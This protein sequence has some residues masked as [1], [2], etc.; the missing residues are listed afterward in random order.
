MAKRK[1]VLKVTPGWLVWHKICPDFHSLGLLWWRTHAPSSDYVMESSRQQTSI[2]AL[3]SFCAGAVVAALLQRLYNSHSRRKTLPPTNLTRGAK[4]RGGAS[5]S[6]ITCGMCGQQKPANAF[7]PK[8]QK[9][10]SGW[11]RAKCN[12]CI[13]TY[14]VTF[15]ANAKSAAAATAVLQ[16]P[17]HS[18]SAS[19][20]D[21]SDPIRKA[22]KAETVLR[23]RTERILLVLEHCSDDLN[24]VAVM[25]TCEA[26]GIYRVWLI[27]ADAKQEATAR[28]AG[29]RA[30]Q[31][32]QVRASE[33]GFDFDRLL[34]GKRAQ[35]YLTHLDVRRFPSVAECVAALRAD[36]RTVWVTDLSQEALPLP[37]DRE[38]V[39]RMLPKRVAVVLGSE[40]AGISAAMLAAADERIF[41]PMFGFTES[42]NLSV[43]A[44]LVLQTLLEACPESR[45]DLPEAE[46]AQIR[47]AWYAQLAKTEG[48]RLEFEKL[49]K[50]GGAEPLRDTR[51]P[52][53][54]RDEH[55]NYSRRE[56]TRLSLVEGR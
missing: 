44:A 39:G 1:L 35:N 38:E 28:N 4:P 12:D 51:R 47:R 53:C 42:F 55:R 20:D 19:A 13:A 14:E 17:S 43:S 33:R 32:L 41:L 56:A 5:S 27:E 16:E 6:I 54:H 7:S 50:R 22:R 46:A 49:A 10:H 36:E 18:V 11:R 2:V 23:A 31:R 15:A 37:L 3:T 48:Q 40:G 25:R 9:K 8:Q 34:G 24:H 45:G 26:L 29:P 21:A 30:V 52:Q